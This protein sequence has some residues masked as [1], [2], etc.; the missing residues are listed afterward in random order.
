MKFSAI[1][2]RT[3]L[4]LAAAPLL[5]SVA[6]GAMAQAAWPDKMV[7]LTEKIWENAPLT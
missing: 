2:R 4:A 3:A 5:A 6:G 7:K 1:T